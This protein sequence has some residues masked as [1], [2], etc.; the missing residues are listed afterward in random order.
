MAVPYAMRSATSD[1]PSGEAIGGMARE[2]RAGLTAR[3]R[4]LPSKYF[5]DDRG[6]RLFERIT[7]LPEY[8]Q[9]RTETAL[10]GTLADALIAA[11]RPS[12]IVEL[13]MPSVLASIIHDGS[14]RIAQTR[15]ETG[16]WSRRGRSTYSC[17]TWTK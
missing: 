1:A 7:M 8:Y 13:G 2:V 11:L 16:A 15:R 12:E 10:L 5:Y 4:W 9:T 14:L 3:P 17:S 6:S